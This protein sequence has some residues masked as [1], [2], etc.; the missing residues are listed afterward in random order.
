MGLDVMDDKHRRRVGDAVI[1]DPNLPVVPWATVSAQFAYVEA[2]FQLARSKCKLFQFI[3]KLTCNLPRCER[4]RVVEPADVNHPWL[5]SR[6]IV[7]WAQFW[8]VGHRVVLKIGGLGWLR[9]AARHFLHFLEELFPLING[10]FVIYAP[11]DPL[12]LFV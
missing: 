9:C 4:M 6:G 1:G 10:V 5:R 7:V 12:T 3:N 2:P 11:I 8:K